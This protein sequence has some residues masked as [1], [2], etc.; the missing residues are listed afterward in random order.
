MIGTF[1][2][3]VTPD[4]LGPGSSTRRRGAVLLEAALVL[5][6]L[7]ALTFGV[8][9]FGH[10]FFIEHNLKGAA[11]AGA[12]AGIPYGADNAAA[13]AAIGRMMTAAGLQNSNYTVTITPADV[14]TAP[15]GTDVSVTIQCSWG[16]VG[17]RPLGLISASKNV[18]GV[19]VMR[20]E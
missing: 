5:P 6:I 16:T 18:R 12:R 11:Q 19:A 14:S 9:E 2:K 15:A 4:T 20:K 7:L 1:R 8:I 13:N 3:I 17:V 10:Y